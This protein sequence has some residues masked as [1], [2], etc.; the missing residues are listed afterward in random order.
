MVLVVGVTLEWLSML[1]Y[2]TMWKR[3]RRTGKNLIMAA[4]TFGV[5]LGLILGGIEIISDFGY[6]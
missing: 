1:M 2:L 3:D 5:S 4:V 6:A